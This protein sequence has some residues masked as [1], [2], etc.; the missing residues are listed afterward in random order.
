MFLVET[1]V[2]QTASNNSLWWFSILMT[3][4]CILCRS[5]LFNKPDLDH[6]L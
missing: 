3:Q 2:V 1:D 4:L 6:Q 5:S